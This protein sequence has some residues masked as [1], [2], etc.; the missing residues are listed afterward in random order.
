M[1]ILGYKSNESDQVADLYADAKPF[2]ETDIKNALASALRTIVREPNEPNYQAEFVGL[3]MELFENKKKV[4]Q[5]YI[6]AAAKHSRKLAKNEEYLNEFDKP[7]ERRAALQKEEKFLLGKLGL[8]SAPT[9]VTPPAKP[10]KSALKTSKV[11]S[12]IKNADSK[13]SKSK[14]KAKIADTKSKLTSKAKP[15]QPKKSKIAA[16]RSKITKGKSAVSKK[17][18]GGNIKAKLIA[19]KKKT[20]KAKIVGRRARL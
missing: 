13:T 6:E 9:S 4:P 3:V 12:G 11:N 20:F 19:A 5:M 7:A 15:S 8:T 14:S 17:T 18:K 2:T 1:G 16:K 10:L